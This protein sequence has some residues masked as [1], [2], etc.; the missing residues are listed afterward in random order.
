IGINWARRSNQCGSN[1]IAPSHTI[2]G[3]IVKTKQI[4]FVMLFAL[5]WLNLGGNVRAL[6][7]HD[8][9]NANTSDSKEAKAAKSDAIKANPT[10][11]EQLLILNEKMRK[12]EEVVERQQR[13]IEEL[14]LKLVA[15]PAG[16]SVGDSVAHAAT[17]TSTL[18]NT[19][20]V[21]TTQNPPPA[22]D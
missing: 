13:I 3:K 18:S 8:R 11:E 16:N 1:G 10:T 20:A 9:D 22:D 15:A 5:L 6:E 4:M 14:Q 7:D 2:G 12:M 17:P 21:T 19:V